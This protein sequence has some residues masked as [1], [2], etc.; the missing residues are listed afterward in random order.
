MEIKDINDVSVHSFK[1]TCCFTG[2]MLDEEKELKISHIKEKLLERALKEH[3]I[4]VTCGPRCFQIKNQ[5]LLFWYCI[6]ENLTTKL[7]T[8]SLGELLN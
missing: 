7:I 3:K 6:N 5:E 2:S 8:E 4:I 1:T